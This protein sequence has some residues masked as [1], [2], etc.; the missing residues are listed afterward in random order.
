MT[1]L[2]EP[3]LEAVSSFASLVAAAK[4]A[5]RGK[6]LAPEAARFL[7]D[8]E[9]EVLRLER[10]LRARTWQPGPF[11][12]FIVT[13]PKPRTISAA[14]FRDRVVHHALCAALEPALDAAAS[15]ASQACRVGRGTSGALALARGFTRRHDCFL[16][17]DVRRFF[18][19][20][21]HEV[22]LVQLRPLVADPGLMGLVTR[23]IAAGAPGSVVGK[24]LP[25]GNL[26]SQY[27]A[28]H[29]LSGFD[30][31][32]AARFPGVGYVRYMD[33][34]LC[35]M[36]SS[37]T[38]KKVE[39]WAT[40]ALG[41]LQLEVKSEATRR[42]PVHAGVPFLG[43]RLWPTLVRLDGMRK[44]RLA[45]RLRAVE[46]E[47]AETGDDVRAAQRGA[48]LVGWAMMADTQRLRRGMLGRA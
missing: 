48:S 17:L 37:G 1:P 30:R 14:P 18:E 9:P 41:A 10:E 28:N 38:L 4:R 7:F 13:E 47:L 46:R 42:G 22:L 45:R 16:K 35:F 24:G 23:I 29:Y 19:T 3:T 43:F 6:R 32:L 26:T 27:F 12:T 44:R 33:D 20:L 34:I 21:D 5:A 11:R 2:P 8:L 39:G 31:E 36:E 15:E 25:I 40:T